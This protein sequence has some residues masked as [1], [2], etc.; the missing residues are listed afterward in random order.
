MGARTVQTQSSDRATLG[1]LVDWL[2]DGYQNSVLTGV[3]DA[4]RRADVNLI[5]FAGG[6]LRG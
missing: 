3:A 4:A 2:E 1:L 5:C 6:V